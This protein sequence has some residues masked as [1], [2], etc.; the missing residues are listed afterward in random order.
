M[1]KR[2][3]QRKRERTRGRESVYKHLTFSG[4]RHYLLFYTEN[5][6]LCGFEMT[7]I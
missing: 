6:F 2:R 5:I 1:M 7:A 3:R 4:H